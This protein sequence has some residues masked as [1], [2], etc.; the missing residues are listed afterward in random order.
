MMYGRR[1]YKAEYLSS[2]TQMGK[3][4]A[5]KAFQQRYAR[6]MFLAVIGGSL[7]FFLPTLY[8]IQQNYELFS[9]IALDT[10]PQLMSHLE[11]ETKWLF[12]FMT[13]SLVTVATVTFY[14]SLRMTKNIMSPLGVINKHMSKLMVGAWNT[15]EI[16]IRDE[17]EF[18]D[19]A[20][21]YDY[22]H[23]AL[24]AVA[25]SE[26]KSLEKLNIDPQ[27]REAFRIWKQLMEEKRARLGYSHLDDQAL[28][29]GQIIDLVVKS[30][31]ADSKRHVS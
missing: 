8:F 23:R 7:L 11:R 1:Y 9:G 28:N 13:I 30:N 24:K 31:E 19:L 17:D 3:S 10:A 15:P 14:L 29:E 20:L 25:E 26:L 16:S 2:K 4:E 5:F 6:A 12:N 27:N 21:T 22:F 18:K